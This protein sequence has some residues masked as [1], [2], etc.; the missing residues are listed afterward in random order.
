[1]VHEPE[2]ASL[3]RW[4]G[5]PGACE[6]A[7][8]PSLGAS[9]HR[10]PDVGAVVDRPLSSRF[11]GGAWRGTASGERPGQ[12]SQVVGHEA[13]AD[14]AAKRR[15]AFPEA[16]RQS[17]RAHQ[18]GDDP[19]DARA[20]SQEFLEPARLLQHAA[21]QVS[22]AGLRQRD[23]FDAPVRAR[24][25][26]RGG[27]AGRRPTTALPKASPPMNT[28]SVITCARP[29]LPMNSARYLFQRIS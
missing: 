6:L 15:P 7:R 10:Y 29:V 19:F 23:P 3:C 14:I 21:Q 8:L 20:K 25:L 13:Q 1:M 16:T 4:S 26:R 2:L 11:R 24:P 12:V 27:T 18:G 5:P 17:E 9:G 22:R 28:A